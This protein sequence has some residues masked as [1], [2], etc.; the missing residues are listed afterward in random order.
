[1]V[2]NPDIFD[3]LEDDRTI[4]E[5]GP[6]QSLAGNGQLMGYLHKGFWQCMDT[7]R[8]KLKLEKLWASGNAPW[9][10]W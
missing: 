7:Q 4:L 8:E 6:M 3:Y 10:N 1:M 9:K 5:Q 2:F